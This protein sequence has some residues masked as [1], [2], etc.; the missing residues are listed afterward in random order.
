VEVVKVGGSLFDLPDLGPRLAAWLAGRAERAALLVPGGGPTTDVVRAF[1]RRFGLGEE[2]AHW[3]ALRALALNARVLA[4]LLPAACVVGGVEE[5]PAAWRTGRVPVLDAHAFAQA[6]AA[7]RL[8]H[9]WDAG[10]DAV[11]ARVAVAAGAARLVLLKSVDLPQGIDWD[12]A[13]RRGLV[14]PWFGRVLRQARRP[15]AV[16]FVNLRCG[17]APGRAEGAR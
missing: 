4:D 1:D 6:D 14:D 15:P 10:S 8:P 7:D 12:E 11:A 3:L 2:K 5:C 17:F 13:G 16:E 9:C